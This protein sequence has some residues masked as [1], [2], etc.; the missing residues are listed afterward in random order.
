[1]IYFTKNSTKSIYFIKRVDINYKNN[2]LLN[3]EIWRG[4]A[5]KTFGNKIMTL[6]HVTNKYAADII[7]KTR[8][9][10]CG[11]IG[12]FGAGIYFAEKIT[13]AQKKST[14]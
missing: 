3:H 14:S 7:N 2:Y 1:M 5:R 13:T 12:R 10:K 6:Y 8:T 11:K 4:P 9:M